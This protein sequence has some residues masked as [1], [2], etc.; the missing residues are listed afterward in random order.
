MLLAE[1]GTTNAGPTK[2]A[3]NISLLPGE[4]WEE[5]VGHLGSSDLWGPRQEQWKVA[6][7]Q[8]EG[9][10]SVLQTQKQIEENCPRFELPAYG[11]LSTCPGLE[12]S[13]IRQRETTLSQEQGHCPGPAST[14]LTQV[15]PSSPL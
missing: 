10:F 13:G 14:A 9:E 2:C 15:D 3:Q 7:Y 4:G 8:K 6:A 1:V 11:I 5:S 12:V